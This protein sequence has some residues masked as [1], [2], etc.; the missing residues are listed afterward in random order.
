MGYTDPA[1]ATAPIAPR[2]S[3]SSTSS[4]STSTSTVTSRHA[5]A[6]LSLVLV[7]AVATAIVVGSPT[8]PSF[9]RKQSSGL[10]ANVTNVDASGHVLVDAVDTNVA[11]QKVNAERTV[12]DIS[13]DWLAHAE[14]VRVEQAGK[15]EGAAPAELLEPPA[16]P[17]PPF[18]G[19]TIGQL[20]MDME[21]TKNEIDAKIATLNTMQSGAA[22]NDLKAEVR[23]L[24]DQKTAMK[25]AI[26]RKKD[27]A[28]ILYAAGAAAVAA[29]IVD[30]TA[31]SSHEMTT[32]DTL[33]TTIIRLHTAAGE[34][35]PANWKSTESLAAIAAGVEHPALR[36]S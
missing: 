9:V 6:G 20:T 19:K 28:P 15:S 3:C 11:E 27:S 33:C 4:T 18:E 36:H 35:V 26:K 22:K 12:A 31:Y 34:L 21:R 1:V 17:P 2:T 5:K 8:L 30:V 7:A 16:P 13:A 23:S 10:F 14:S 25:E 24:K 32:R 29:A